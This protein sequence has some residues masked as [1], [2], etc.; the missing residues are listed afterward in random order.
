MA[1]GDDDELWDMATALERVTEYR[2]CQQQPGRE[3]LADDTGKYH[4]ACTLTDLDCGHNGALDQDRCS[5]ICQGDEDHGWHGLRCQD[6]YGK[7]VPGIGSGGASQSVDG[8][9]VGNRCSPDVQCE[10]T[11]VCCVTWFSAICCEFGNTCD[12]TGGTECACAVGEA[13]VRANLTLPAQGQL[14]V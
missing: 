12:C 3:W 1:S 7:C 4:C 11:D 8:C 6:T 9:N 5:C 13:E 2:A 14:V 10:A